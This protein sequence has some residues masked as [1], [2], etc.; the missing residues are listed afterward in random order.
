MVGFSPAS[1][2]ARA[3]CDAITH[4]PS[5]AGAPCANVASSASTT[6]RRLLVYPA[7]PVVPR[8]LHRA[9]PSGTPGLLRLLRRPRRLCLPSQAL[10]LIIELPSRP[11]TFHRLSCAGRRSRLM[12]RRRPPRPRGDARPSRNGASPYPGQRTQAS[13]ARPPSATSFPKA[14]PTSAKRMCRR[15]APLPSPPIA[16][17]VAAGPL[18]SSKT[19]RSS[20][21]SFTTGLTSTRAAGG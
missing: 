8:Q 6:L 20:K 13:S 15:P 4:S 17:S 1:L 3:S 5:A 9:K 19:E 14:W 2:V 12:R 21:N 11:A 10:H 18:S 16:F 7:R